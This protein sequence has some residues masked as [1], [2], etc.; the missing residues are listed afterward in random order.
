MTTP[1]SH[2]MCGEVDYEVF[3]EGQ[4]IDSASSP[5]SF[6]TSTRTFEIYSEDFNLVGLR[7]IEVKGFLRDYPV[8]TSAIP[9]LTTSI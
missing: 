3:F 2:L 6:D 7:T 1:L 5:V 4:S 8:L 9:N